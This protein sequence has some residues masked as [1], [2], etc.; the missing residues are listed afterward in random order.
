MF[1]KLLIS[2]LD[3]KN[4]CFDSNIIEIGTFLAI[5]EKK[6]YCMAAILNFQFFGGKN[7]KTSCFLAVLNSTLFRAQCFKFSCF[8]PD[9]HTKDTFCYI[10]ALLM[11]ACLCKMAI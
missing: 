1:N 10:S 2:F 5:L 9:V 4:I 8:Y 3:L 11:G 6:M 7:G